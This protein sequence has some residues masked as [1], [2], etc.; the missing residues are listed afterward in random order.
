MVCAL[1]HQHQTML[2]QQKHKNMNT[3]KFSPARRMYPSPFFGSLPSLFEDVF[4]G[5]DY[6]SFVPAVNISEND[7]EWKLE[8]SAPGFSK[9]DFKI[10]L[11]KEVLSVS[12]EHKEEVNKNEKNY[13][14]REFSYGS[15]SRS[16]RIKENTVDVEKIGAAYENGILNIT[17]PKMEVAPEK[18]VKEIKIS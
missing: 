6:A 17:L 3:L 5:K 10:N 7:K 11:E 15:F 8:V 9:E 4:S 13:T 1:C 14:R 2:N 18:A 12:A 16:F